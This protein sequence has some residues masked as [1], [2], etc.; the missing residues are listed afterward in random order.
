YLLKHSRRVRQAVN[1]PL[2]YLG[3]VESLD[4]AEKALSEGFQCTA[5]GRT[6]IHNPN[7]INQCR[8]GTTRISGCDHCNGCVARMYSPGGTSCVHRP[9]NDA[10]RNQ[11]PAAS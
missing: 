1:L 10:A 9:P 7:L 11:Q 2:A 3:G 8:N 6:L 5:M 4:A